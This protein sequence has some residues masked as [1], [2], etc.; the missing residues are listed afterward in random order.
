MTNHERDQLKTLIPR[1]VDKY[2]SF[3]DLNERSL[4]RDIGDSSGKENGPSSAAEVE[5]SSNEE[6]KSLQNLIS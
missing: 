3:K 4:E 5:R 1:I 6:N 2:G